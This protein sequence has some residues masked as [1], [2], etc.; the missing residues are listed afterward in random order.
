MLPVSSSF[1]NSI[2]SFPRTITASATLAGSAIND[3]YE[4][5]VTE[6]LDPIGNNAPPKEAHIT[7]TNQGF[8]PYAT[9]LQTKEVVTI[10]FTLA[11]PGG[12]FESVPMGTFYLYNWHNNDDYMTATL[13]ARDLLDVMSGTK[14][15]GM[16][17]ARGISL[18]DLAIAI[19]QDF[20]NQSGMTVT[21][22]IDTALQS[23][24]TKGLVPLMSHRDALMYVA[25]AGTAVMWMDRFN[26]LQIKQSVANQPLNI[27]PYTGEL[28]LFMQETYPK[29]AT[30]NPYNYFTANL[31]SYGESSVAS[32]IFSGTFKITGTATVWC[33]YNTSA[34]GA[35]VTQTITGGTFVSGVYYADGANITVSGGTGNVLITLSGNTITSTTSQSV[36]NNA[37]SQPINQVD[38]SKNPLLT[39]TPM[40]TNVLNWAAAECQGI[41]LYESESW[42]DL[43]LECGDVI[44]WDSQYSIG[45]KQAKIIRQEFRFNGTL[46]GTIN[47]KG[48]G[49][50]YTPVSPDSSGGSSI[51]EMVQ[52]IMHVGSHGGSLNTGV[53]VTPG[54]ADRAAMRIVPGSLTGANRGYNETLED[55]SIYFYDGNGNEFA[56]IHPDGTTNLSSSGGGGGSNYFIYKSYSEVIAYSSYVMGTPVEFL[57]VVLDQQCGF[58][59]TDNVP[60]S[61]HLI[62]LSET[63]SVTLT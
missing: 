59:L 25:Q 51:D 36:I 34:D 46:S 41:Y 49:A 52:D 56:Y 6:E 3:I 33:A 60:L 47:G 26:I 16:W 37:S 57:S 18:S 53:D 1:H 30:Q 48:L 8:S 19:I 31:S 54:V 14:Y 29:I 38:L 32:I 61:A 35:T 13:Y 62:S 22:Q 50:S 17:A 5:V 43:S 15:V 4:I 55:G 20:E 9:T 27:M 63:L 42:M 39:T 58:S 7:L 28:T 21:Y 40:V 2:S 44:Y 11:L 45:T 24:I 10:T 23:I 12:G